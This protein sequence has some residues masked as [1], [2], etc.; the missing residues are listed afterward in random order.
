M[1]PVT[2]EKTAPRPDLGVGVPV[3]G[4]LSDAPEAADGRCR[5]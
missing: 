2:C 1:E 5:S 4:V 3:V